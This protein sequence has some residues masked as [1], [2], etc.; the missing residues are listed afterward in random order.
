M[1]SFGVTIRAQ[2]VTPKHAV[3]D[4]GEVFLTYTQT[5]HEF[6]WP[7]R[8]LG[9]MTHTYVRP[10][11]GA[12]HEWAGHAGPVP[13]SI[14]RTR[15]TPYLLPARPLWPGLA[16]DTLIWAALIWLALLAMTARRRLRRRRGRCVR[17]GYDLRGAAHDQCPECG[18]ASPAVPRPSA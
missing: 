1:G 3:P 4:Q 16:A 18:A 2:S 12:L 7:F 6:G 15:L 13:R 10:R 11:V 9:Y 8:A 14:A 5:F 17:C